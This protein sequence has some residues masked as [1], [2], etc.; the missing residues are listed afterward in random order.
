M[1]VREIWRLGLIQAI[2]S[3]WASES[4]SL[5]RDG[6]DSL[7]NFHWT[8]LARNQ[9]ARVP[10]GRRTS[11]SPILPMVSDFALAITLL[12]DLEAKLYFFL[13]MVVFT[14]RVAEAA[15]QA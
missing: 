6:S 13:S 12:K 7:Q 15:A 9:N 2:P 8:A 11:F 14:P 10:E 3:N 5:C 1:C 4:S